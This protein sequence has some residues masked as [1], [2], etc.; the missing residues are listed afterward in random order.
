MALDLFLMGFSAMVVIMSIIYQLFINILQL[1]AFDIF[2]RDPLLLRKIMHV[3]MWFVGLFLLRSHKRLLESSF[4]IE[5]ALFQGVLVFVAGWYLGAP[6]SLQLTWLGLTVAL[7]ALFIESFSAV[8][9][10]KQVEAIWRVYPPQ[11]SSNDVQVILRDYR[12][13][14]YFLVTVSLVLLMLQEI[15][16]FFAVPSEITEF[17][18]SV[19]FWIIL[20]LSMA[21]YYFGLMIMLKN[22]LRI[23]QLQLAALFSRLEV[24]PVQLAERFPPEFLASIGLSKD[25]L[26]HS[27]SVL[28]VKQKLYEKLTQQRQASLAQVIEY[29]KQVTTE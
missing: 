4:S 29:M 10:T 22:E 28:E 9:I 6:S 8:L 14:N 1:E 17:F 7:G 19:G 20:F 15:E 12:W 25:E 26:I 16:T 23:D 11:F 24:D 18:T 21:L 27:K 3:G 13:A 5:W 2:W